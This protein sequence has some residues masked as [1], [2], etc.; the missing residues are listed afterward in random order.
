MTQ[1]D[2]PSPKPLPDPEVLAVAHRRSF[3]AKYKLR[4]LR[5]LDAATAPGQAGEVLR[6]EGLYSS[7]I[8]DW[9]RKREAGELKGLATK[10]LGRPK[11]E[12]N[13]VDARVA[14]LEREL[15]R[16]REDLRK[17]RI[18]IAVQKKVAEMLGILSTDSDGKDS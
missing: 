10:T 4:I 17:A 12:R 18:I 2:S 9:R 14:G 7:H 1:S 16:A 11:K 13:P 3:T 15:A 5:E 8:T 6:R